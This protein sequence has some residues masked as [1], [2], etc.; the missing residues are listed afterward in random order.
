MSCAFIVQTSCC[1]HIFYNLYSLHCREAETQTV[2]TEDA[3][4]PHV[5]EETPGSMFSTPLSKIA[6]PIFTWMPTGLSKQ[7]RTLDLGKS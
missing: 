6:S 2:E 3:R 5:R 7:R 1:K 4:Q